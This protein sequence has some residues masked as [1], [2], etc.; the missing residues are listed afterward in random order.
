MTGRQ[1]ALF[2]VAWA[3]CCVGVVTVLHRLDVG[4]A[5]PLSSDTM[6]KLASVLPFALLLLAA[7]PILF[8]VRQWRRRR[9]GIRR[10]AS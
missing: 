8:A 6:I 9:R 5:V 2:S 4:I 7:A 3:L 1:F 10:A